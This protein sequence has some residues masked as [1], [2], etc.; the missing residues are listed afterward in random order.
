M[1]K[2][3]PYDSKANKHHFRIK[4]SQNVMSFSLTSKSKL[5]LLQVYE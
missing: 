1:H 3:Y 2:K 4:H 5:H